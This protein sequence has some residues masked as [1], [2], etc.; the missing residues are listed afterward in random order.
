MLANLA[1][2]T[3]ARHYCQTQSNYWYQHTTE[4]RQT[5]PRDQG[6]Y[7]QMLLESYARSDVLTIIC[8][9]LERLD[10][11]H[12]DDIDITRDGLRPAFGHR[13][14]QIGRDAQ[15]TPSHPN[16]GQPPPQISQ[17]TIGVNV[18]DAI[19]NEREA[20][21]TYIQEL[22]ESQLHAVQ[23]LPYQRVLSPAEPR[24][25]WQ[26]LRNRWKIISPYW[27]PLH[28]RNLS[29]ITAFNTDAFEAFCESFSLI[30]RLSNRGITRIWE[31]RDYG[32]EY[33]QDISLFDPAYN[34]N[35]GY[36]TSNR[37]DWIVYA[38]HE[39]STTVGGWLLEEI[40]EQWLDWEKHTW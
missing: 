32:I 37:L 4:I 22:S 29:D 34:G 17:A 14:V 7:Q 5:I 23:P 2:H 28:P 20:F 9:E 24:T 11:D 1:L 40:K 15:K 25:L 27:H 6:N 31:L 26:G 30:D 39:D 18:D 36:W 21:C 3:A 8:T 10:P 33:E 35:E 38:S 16:M 19:T 12:L 13:I